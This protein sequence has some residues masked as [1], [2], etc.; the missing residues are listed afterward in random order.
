MSEPEFSPDD[1]ELS[2]G[3]VLAEASRILFG[4]VRESPM[5]ACRT[6]GAKNDRI[7][8]NRDTGRERCVRCQRFV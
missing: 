2:E 1:D 7:I 6:C 3:D 5:L 4:T 8:Y